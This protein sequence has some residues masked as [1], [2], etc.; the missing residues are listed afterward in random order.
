[1]AR[2]KT[3]AKP[4]AKKAAARMPAA[5]KADAKGAAAKKPAAKKKPPPARKTTTASG[6]LAAG[7]MSAIALSIGDVVMLTNSNG[8]VLGPG[9]LCAER[10]AFG[11]ACVNF[12]GAIGCISATRSRLSLAPPGSPAPGCDGCNDC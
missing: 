5:T 10:P 1:M 3:P 4:A 7:S 11:S 9:R 2:S 8:T 6:A 12:G